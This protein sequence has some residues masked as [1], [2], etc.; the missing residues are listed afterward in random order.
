MDDIVCVDGSAVG[1]VTATSMSSLVYNM[2]IGTRTG[3]TYAAAAGASYNA[4]VSRDL[5]LDLIDTGI[6]SIRNK[7][8]EPKLM[9]MGWDEYFALERLLNAHQR[10]M[11]QETFQVGVGDERTLPGTRTG[12]ILST[13]MGI[14]IIPDVDTPKSVAAASDTVL[15]SNI[16]L[17][18]TDYIEVAVAM[19]PQYIENRDFFAATAMV[20]RGL[21]YMM[22]ET[23][24][25]RVDCQYKVCDLSGS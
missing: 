7:G 12:L 16:Y 21:V 20:V 4:G 5:T 11:G 25:T 9:S 17:F 22:A 1:G 14:P 23:R 3:G 10:Y 6:Y 8:G 24:C 15:G 13:Y 19:Q 18:D 2:T